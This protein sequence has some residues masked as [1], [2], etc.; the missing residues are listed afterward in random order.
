MKLAHPEL[1]S[2]LASEYVLGTMRGRTRRRF[3]EYLKRDA[4]LRAE[5]AR[6]EERLTPLAERLAPVEP[7][8]R[9][10]QRIEA[11]LD[12]AAS[13]RAAMEAPRKSGL[14]HSLEFWR[15]LGLAASVVA[16][17]LLAMQFAVKP[18]KPDPILTAVLAEEANN[19][20]RL[21]IEQPRANVLNIKM[22]K[23][24]ANGPEKQHQLWVF[25]ANGGAPR[26][27]GIINS[28]GDTLLNLSELDSKLI[29]GAQFAVSIEAVGG[30]QSGMPGRIV[31]KGTIAW[32]P[33][34][35]PLPPKQT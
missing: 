14:W 32:I 24:W 8:A 15:N 1:R 19:A 20:V 5:V 34:R 6:W 17:T 35:P 25:P 4:T 30:S 29:D 21:F 7:P 26:S 31:C 11:R 2:R 27:I 33:K 10:W 23:P 22:V 3:E 13:R 18:A 28:K 12:R 16:A 9:V